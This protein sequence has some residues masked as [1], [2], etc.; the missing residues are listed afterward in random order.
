M[1]HYRIVGDINDME[2]IIKIIEIS[3]REDAYSG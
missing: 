2:C 1:G 3:T